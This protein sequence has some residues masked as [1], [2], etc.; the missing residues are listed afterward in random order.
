MHTGIRK[1]IFNKKKMPKCFECYTF[2]FDFDRAIFIIL[3][4]SEV[5]EFT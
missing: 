5:V 3:S 4:K 2:S 1:Y